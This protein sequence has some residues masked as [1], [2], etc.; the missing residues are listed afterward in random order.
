MVQPWLRKLEHLL[1][2]D[3][4]LTTGDGG[5][6]AVQQGGLADAPLVSPHGTT[7]LGG[8]LCTL[9]QDRE[10][11]GLGVKRQLDDCRADAARRGWT[12][13]EEYV[14]DDIS[15]Y[16]GR[17]R[18]AYERMLT[19]I[20]TGRR[21]AVIVWHM[22]RLH[23]QPIE[24]ERFADV[25]ARADLTDVKTLHGDMD[26][27][28][29]DGLLLARLLAAVAA[30]ESDGKSRRGKRKMRE[31][32][33]AGKPHGG[34]SRPFGFL[35]SD[36]ATHDPVEARAIQE[37]AA[38]VLAGESL[39]SVAAWL[40]ES[41]VRT[42]YGNTWRTTTLRGL[43]LNPRIYGQRVHQGKAIGPGA[44]EPII[45]AEDGERLRLLLTDPAR[46]TNRTARRYLLSGLCR[47]ALCG[48]KMYSVPRFDTARYLCRSG[49]DFGGCGRMAITAA[50]LEAWITEAVLQRLDSMGM[51]EALAGQTSD[52]AHAGALHVQ[53]QTDTERLAEL[54]ILW[55]DGELD[56]VQ[57]KAARS[58]LEQRVADNRRTLAR[59]RG[60][61]V[62][63]DWIGNSRQLR[64]RW[65]GLALSGQTAIVRAVIDHVVIQP[66]TT[67]GRTGLDPARVQ[68]VWRL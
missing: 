52:D 19:D 15:A 24:L 59:L 57:W 6:Q 13:G 38:R 35:A 53:V 50:H 49:H 47:C 44:W 30:I 54:A 41:D 67:R 29:G 18:P 9:S 2:G 68:P 10:G 62:V 33:E 14:D 16:S 61:T 7:E 43:L 63:D 26:L 32:A 39:T 55:A 65:S 56:Q 21:D 37:A 11:D 27:G 28:T 46:R 12:V 42:V 4:P 22:D 40:A 3:H 8:H 1:A 25:C 45:S 5:G 31:L 64:A 60:S 51:A 23:R 20:G 66:A 36:G 34:G 48:T 58:R 17:T